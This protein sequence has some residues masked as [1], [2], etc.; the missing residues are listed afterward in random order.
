MRL[1]HCPLY[2]KSKLYTP[3]LSQRELPYIR[4]CKMLGEWPQ[5]LAHLALRALLRGGDFSWLVFEV[6]GSPLP[7]QAEVNPRLGG[8]ARRDGVGQQSSYLADLLAFL[9]GVYTVA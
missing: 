7:I 5:L 6:I 2:G 3:A 4:K 1:S 9:T 8:V